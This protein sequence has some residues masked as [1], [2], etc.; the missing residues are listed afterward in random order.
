M[1]GSE[2]AVRRALTAMRF[3]GE[4]N[5]KVTREIAR[6]QTP[7]ADAGLDDTFG[8]EKIAM[9]SQD[10]RDLYRRRCVNE[11]GRRGHPVPNPANIPADAESTV[12]EVG[13]ALFEHSRH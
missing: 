5:H 10:V 12:M 3:E 13:D 7:V 2:A 11:A 1:A 6:N 8:G 4:W 9:F